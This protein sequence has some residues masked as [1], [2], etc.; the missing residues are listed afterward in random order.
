MTYYCWNCFAEMR[1]PGGACPQCGKPQ[2]IDRRDYIAKLRAAVG[3]PLAETRRRAIFLLGEK[4]VAEAV[5]DLARVLDSER[6]PFLAEEAM[7]ALG[8]IGGDEAMRAVIARARHRSFMVRAR[9]VEALAAAGGNW[10]RIAIEIA[11]EDPSAMV[12]AAA[13]AAG[14]SRH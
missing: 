6:D 10:A 13:A 5:G 2:E 12:R 3:H 7:I 1:A 4:R 11:R 9:A 8:K 14:I